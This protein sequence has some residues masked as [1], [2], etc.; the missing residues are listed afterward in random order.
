MIFKTAKDRLDAQDVSLEYCVGDGGSVPLP[1]APSGL[2]CKQLWW[3]KLRALTASR[4]SITHDILISLAPWLIISILMLPCA[5]VVNILPAIP[6]MLRICLPTRER[7][8]ISLCIVTCSTRRN[9]HLGNYEKRLDSWTFVPFR[10]FWA[11]WPIG[12]EPS[13]PVHLR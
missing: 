6:T 8:A 4:A 7:I 1:L 5:R 11:H 2:I 13:L 12:Q 3:I 10:F 9:I